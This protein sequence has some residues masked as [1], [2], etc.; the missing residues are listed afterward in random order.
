[1]GFEKP[2][3]FHVIFFAVIR[4]ASIFLA[5]GRHFSA[6]HMVRARHF[7]QF[8]SGLELLNYAKL[9]IKTTSPVIARAERTG[10]PRK[11]SRPQYQNQVSYWW[12]PKTHH[13]IWLKSAKKTT[14][15][16]KTTKSIPQNIV[17]FFKTESGSTRRITRGRVSRSRFHTC[18]GAF[19]EQVVFP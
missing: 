19:R 13:N 16:H 11:K 8:N 9:K 17:F 10:Q 7:V 18:L 4:C 6:R 1:M 15:V 3:R 5:L 2:S 12:S 14:I